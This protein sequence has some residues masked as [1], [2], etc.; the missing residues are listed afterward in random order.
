MSRERSPTVTRT[1]PHVGA[2]GLA[3]LAGALSMPVVSEATLVD[4]TVYCEEFGFIT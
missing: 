4:R 3:V 1:K 2:F